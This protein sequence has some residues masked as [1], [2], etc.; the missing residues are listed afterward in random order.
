VTHIPENARIADDPIEVRREAEEARREE[1][2]EGFNR[3]LLAIAED[4]RFRLAVAIARL[5]VLTAKLRG[6]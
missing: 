2:E 3:Q 6:D 5:P 4:E 1:I